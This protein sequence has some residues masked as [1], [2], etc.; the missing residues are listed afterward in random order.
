MAIM[1]SIPQF[2]FSTDL[3]EVIT[4][5]TTVSEAVVSVSLT[6]D[7]EVVW[8]NELYAYNGNMNLYDVRQIIERY[9][10][11]ND[12][13]QGVC[14]IAFTDGNNNM[15]TGNFTVVLSD[16]KLPAADIW[17]A[18]HFLSTR[19]YQLINRSGKQK[20]YW[21]VYGA[22]TMAY[23]IVATVENDGQMEE[24]T[25]TRKA[26]GA[27]SPGL[28]E[29]NFNVE[30]I[31]EHFAN[32]GILRAFAVNHGNRSMKFFIMDEDPQMVV[33]IKNNFNAE[34]YVPLWGVT[35]EKNKLDAAEAQYLRSKVKYDFDIN[36]EFEFETAMV[37]KEEGDFLAQVFTAQKVMKVEGSTQ[38]EILVEGDCE[39]S[40]SIADV[41][42]IKFTYQYANN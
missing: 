20:L 19:K 9:I 18:D 16:R 4:V 30:D 27:V 12:A 37:S 17:L 32:S 29:Y 21:S 15:N 31:E 6:V 2:C 23:T 1:T 33:I 13:I 34:E 24:V 22:Q 41:N 8:T 3:P 10:R 28:Y 42:R 36:Q 7:S 25:W 14:A 11:Q 40:D 39:I 38:R 5:S 35:V 26:N